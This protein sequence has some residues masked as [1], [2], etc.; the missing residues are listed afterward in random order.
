MRQM[1]MT[2]LM[3]LAMVSASAQNTK[4]KAVNER[5]FDAKVR[6]MVYQLDITKEQQ[7][8]FVPIY[9]RYSEEMQAEW[10]RHDK[11]LHPSNSKEAAELA[12]RK[13]ERQQRS[14]AIRIKYIDQ[15]A[16]VL[17]A[18]QINR[19]FEVETAIQK[20]LMQRIMKS[21]RIRPHQSR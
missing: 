16:T 17:N 6:E 4:Q 2:L 15:F 8:K 5:L 14:Q 11:P 12:K 3:M 10:N 18:D 7:E 20:K 9:R 1:I 21:M 19:F 13:M